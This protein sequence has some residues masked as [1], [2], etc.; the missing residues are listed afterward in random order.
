MFN[1]GNFAPVKFVSVNFVS[2]D[3]VSV[4]EIISSSSLKNGRWL[5][6]LNG[7][8]CKQAASRGVFSVGNAA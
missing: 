2:P 3:F 5:T 7:G 4:V 1:F 6:H 8:T